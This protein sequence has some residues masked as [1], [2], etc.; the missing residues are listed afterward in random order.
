MALAFVYLSATDYLADKKIKALIWYVISVLMHV[1]AIPT[2]IIFLLK[3]KYIKKILSHEIVLLSVFGCIGILFSQ[4]MSLLP[5]Y[6][7]N[8]YFESQYGEGPTRIASIADF[9][10]VSML[11]LLS[12]CKENIAWKNHDFF[13]ILFLFTIG[14]S[15][16]GLFLPS[17]NRIEFLFKPFALVYVINNFHSL[18]K[19]KRISVVLLFCLIAVYQVVAFII[20]PEWL[21]IFSY[22]FV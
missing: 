20:R 14:M 18:S 6:Y 21:G 7:A 1:T 3:S 17:F 10:M 19:W 8:Y 13:K 5:D 22:S 15:F 9:T 4:V 12:R 11:Y 2:G 16:L